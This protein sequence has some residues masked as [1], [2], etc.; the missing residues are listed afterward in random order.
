MINLDFSFSSNSFS[1]NSHNPET[2]VAFWSRLSR[3][4]FGRSVWCRCS[5]TMFFQTK[6]QMP[7][8]YSKRISMIIFHSHKQLWKQ[9]VVRA[10]A[11]RAAD[12]LVRE[13]GYWQRQELED[14]RSHLYRVLHHPNFHHGAFHAECVWNR[15]AKE[16]MAWSCICIRHG[17]FYPWGFEKAYY[18][19]VSR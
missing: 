2:A 16:W 12:F 17:T 1:I 7:R 11:N 13:P 10:N 5:R 15:K 8:F 4:I 6:F 14:H 18:Q 19:V 3:C 9:V